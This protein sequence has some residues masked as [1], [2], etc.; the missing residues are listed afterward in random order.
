MS[1]VQ[2]VIADTGS[3]EVTLTRQQVNHIVVTIEAMFAGVAVATDIASLQ[4][5]FAAIDVSGLAQIV[6]TKELPRPPL[7]P[8]T[9][10]TP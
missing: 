8:M 6:A 2:P 5:A 10:A 9:T 4:T 1:N 3:E 7:F